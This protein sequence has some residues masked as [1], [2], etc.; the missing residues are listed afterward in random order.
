MLALKSKSLSPDLI[1]L[2][3]SHGYERKGYPMHN[4]QTQLRFNRTT[5]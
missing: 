5:L 1:V 2:K 4:N 3:H